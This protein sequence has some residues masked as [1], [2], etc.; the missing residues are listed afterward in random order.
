VDVESLVTA[1]EIAKRLEVGR[2]VVHDWPRQFPEFP[3][4]LA[5]L[6]SVHVWAWPDLES[7]ARETARLP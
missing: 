7:W 6:A 4:P 2:T 3:E 5:E 1:V